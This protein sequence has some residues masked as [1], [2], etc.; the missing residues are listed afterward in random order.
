MIR[1]AITMFLLMAAFFTL[2][3]NTAAAPIPQ[4]PVSHASS[5]S[6]GP[7]VVEKEAVPALVV[8]AVALAGVAYDYAM[9][10]GWVWDLQMLP[11]QLTSPDVR[12]DVAFNF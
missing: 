7:L 9:D 8:A 11:I 12:A 4:G 3:L 1:K 10:K 5:T 2:V 6:N